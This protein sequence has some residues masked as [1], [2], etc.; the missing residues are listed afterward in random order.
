VKKLSEIGE[1]NEELDTEHNRIITAIAMEKA[2]QL[3]KEN[4][5]KDATKIIDNAIYTIAASPSS[6]NCNISFINNNIN[7]NN[8]LIHDLRKSQIGVENVSNYKSFGGKEL[9]MNSN[10]HYKQ[11][12]VHSSTWS[13][14]SCYSN[15]IKNNMLINYLNFN[16]NNNDINNNNNNINNINNNNNNHNNVNNSNINLQGHSNLN[17]SFPLFN[18]PNNQSGA[19]IVNHRNDNNNDGNDGNNAPNK[20]QPPKPEPKDDK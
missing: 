14:Q 20:P 11:R 12:N 6:N 4:K 8:N 5:F 13:G 15:N 9:N 19:N 2:N 17:I 16:N 18:N 10:A 3:A 1:R 7:N